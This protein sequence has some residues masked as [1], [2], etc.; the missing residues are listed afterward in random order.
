MG[1]TTF[2]FWPDM[3]YKYK[4][5]H[6]YRIHPLEYNEIDFEEL[7]YLVQSKSLFGRKFAKNCKGLNN[8]IYIIDK[9]LYYCS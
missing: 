8:A 3:E 2:T 7:A 1:A 5:K 6:F 9:Y 4:S